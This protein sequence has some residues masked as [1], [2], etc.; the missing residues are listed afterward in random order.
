LCSITKMSQIFKREKSLGQITSNPNTRNPFIPASSVYNINL[1]ITSSDEIK[2]TSLVLVP[3]DRNKENYLQYHFSLRSFLLVA[4]TNTGRKYAHTESGPTN[5]RVNDIANQTVR[6]GVRTELRIPP[7]SCKDPKKNKERQ[8]AERIALILYDSVDRKLA[9]QL[10]REIAISPLSE[11]RI[12]QLI[13][14]DNRW[15]LE[16]LQN[17]VF[18]QECLDSFSF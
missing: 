6:E 11:C 16:D 9:L 10:L 7:I 3:Q 15:P 5:K 1:I 17:I 8:D 13:E 12:K 4:Y 2:L 18:L 14:G